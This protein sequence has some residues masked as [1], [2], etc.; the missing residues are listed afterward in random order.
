MKEVRSFLELTGL[1]LLPAAVLLFALCRRPG[2]AELPPVMPAAAIEAPLSAPRMTAVPA[3]DSAESAA[4]RTADAA[5][6]SITVRILTADGIETMTLRDYLLGVVAAEM[7]A[8]FEPE[9]LKAQAV[10]ARTDTLYRMLLAHPHADADCCD[11]PACCKAYS[12]PAALRERW[13]ESCDKWTAKIAEAV[14]GTDGEILTYDGEPIFAA[15][16][17]ASEGATECSEN[18]WLSALP[19]LRS[20]STMETAADVPR[21]RETVTLTQDGLRERLCARCGDISLPDAAADWLTDPVWSESG[22]LLRVQAG[23]VTLSGTSL[24]SLLGLRSTAVTWRLEGEDFIFET[25]G[26]GHGVGMSQYGAEVMAASG[27]DHRE[28][29]LHYY[30]GAVLSGLADVFPA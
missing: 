20:V 26:Y 10:A 21:F 27:A 28:I 8:A 29:L 17:A 13:G 5:D 12:S 18:V 2:G 4:S 22:R 24:R 9:A 14:A 30:S 6:E 7:P 19:Y 25:V 11:D 1:Y 23:G 15:F 16:H 3:S